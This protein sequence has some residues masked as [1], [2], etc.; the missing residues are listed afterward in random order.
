MRPFS[1]TTELFVNVDRDLICI[2][3]FTRRPPISTT[4]GDPTPPS[5]VER[6]LSDIHCA[7]TLLRVSGRGVVLP[8]RPSMG[9]SG[10]DEASEGS[11][12]V[13]VNVRV[14][15]NS[16]PEKKAVSAK[17]GNTRIGEGRDITMTGRL[18][19]HLL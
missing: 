10:D 19:S 11:S 14:Q 7:P 9:E 1:G 15:V 16:S 6:P 4:G 5:D 8:L 3:R 13:L 12:A 17:E 2:N 18:I